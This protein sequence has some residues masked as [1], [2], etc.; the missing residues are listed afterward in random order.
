M[1]EE[2]NSGTKGNNGKTSNA[3]VNKL[4]LIKASRN[5][6]NIRKETNRIHLHSCDEVVDVW[7]FG[8]DK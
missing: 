3:I 4:L 1:A 7:N 2:D 8:A 6:G 5:A